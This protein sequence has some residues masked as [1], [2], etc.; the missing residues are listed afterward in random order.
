M[1]HHHH[2]ASSSNAT[3]AVSPSPSDALTLS[4][5]TP[6]ATRPSSPTQDDKELGKQSEA[7]EPSPLTYDSGS[8]GYFVVLG[9]MLLLLATFGLSTSFGVFQAYYRAVSITERRITPS[10]WPT[11][12]APCPAQNQLAAHPPST[13]SWIGSCQVFFAFG[14]SMAAGRLFDQGL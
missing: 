1:S 5:D 13:I 11:D 9:G 10:D 12:A 3:L 8:R 2:S 6:C 7:E 14:S 4:G